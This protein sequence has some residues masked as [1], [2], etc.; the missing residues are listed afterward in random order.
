MVKEGYQQTEVGVIPEDWEVKKLM[1]VVDY[2]D[3]RGKTPPKQESGIILVTARNIRDGFIDYE[4][5]QEYVSEAEYDKIMRRGKPEI[6]DVLITTEAPLGNV[7]AVDNKNIALAQRVIKYRAKSK[8]L[9]QDYLKYYLLSEKFQRILQDNSSGS[10]A[11]GI[12]GSLLHTLPIV[13][14]TEKEQRSIAQALSDVDALIAALEKAIAKKRALK[15]ATM[16]QLLTGKKRLP[17][18]EK[19]WRTEILANLVQTHNAGIYKKKELYGEGHKIV[20]ISNMY[21]IHAVADQPFDRVPLSKGEID[22]YSL[23]END[24][25][26]GESSLVREEIARTVYVTQ[27]GS[28]T[29][30][31]WH[32]RRY[33]V[34]QNIIH[35]KFLYYYLQASAA[36][37]HMMGNSIQTAIT[38]INTIAYFA[39]PIVLPSIEE[40]REIATVL[41]DMDA[42]IAALETRRAKTQ[43]LKQGMMQQ[44]LT[45]KVRLK[46]EA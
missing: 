30:F 27:E 6:G 40:Q 13:I 10:T 24:L 9:N 15:T 38:G 19:K 5:S 22:Q 34:N 11:Q 17:G 12:K 7:A 16:Q 45:G 25:L 28:G 41:S 37:K 8:K 23:E 21:D 32:T 29:S 3:Y 43:A 44:L 31:A 26:Y 33:R 36:R 46:I 35:T 20:G 39:C 4:S 14:A 1:E 2:V 18:F 42:T